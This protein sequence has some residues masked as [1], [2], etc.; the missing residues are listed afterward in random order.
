MSVAQ[1]GREFEQ[2]VFK[3]YEW[4]PNRLLA[5]HLASYDWMVWF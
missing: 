1:I 5:K 2:I 4:E 3:K